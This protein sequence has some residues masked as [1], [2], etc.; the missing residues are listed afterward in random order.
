MDEEQ[1]RKL[2]EEGLITDKPPEMW[3]PMNTKDRKWQN[4]Y[5]GR[6][7]VTM[8]LGGGWMMNVDTYEL[9]Q[10]ASSSDVDEQLIK[11]VQAVFDDLGYEYETVSDKFGCL[12]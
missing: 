7:G 3:M 10:I 1:F 12:S 11:S 6:G 8:H 2:F 4:Y 9:A 5:S